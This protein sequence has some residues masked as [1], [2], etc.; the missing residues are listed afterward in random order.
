MRAMIASKGCSFT[1]QIAY[2]AM[3]AAFVLLQ[4]MIDSSGLLQ[5]GAGSKLPGPGEHS[6]VKGCV[7][8]GP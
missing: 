4:N 8:G 1:P 5:A 7:A 6:G 2:M 3:W